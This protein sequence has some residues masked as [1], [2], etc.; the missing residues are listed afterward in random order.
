MA[1]YV[2]LDSTANLV[3]SFDREAEARDALEAI[4]QR[5][6]ESADEYAILKYDDNGN[7]VGQATTG[8]QLNAPV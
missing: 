6:P 1:Y 3:E 2:I 4:V 8:S 5:D 7:P